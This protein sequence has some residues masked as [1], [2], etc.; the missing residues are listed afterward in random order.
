MFIYLFV[1]KCN[2]QLEN[3]SFHLSCFLE[4]RQE[5]VAYKKNDVKFVY[6]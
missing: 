1:N 3:D 2:I 5:F 6:I 4:F